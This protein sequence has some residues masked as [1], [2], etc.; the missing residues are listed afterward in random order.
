M[1]TF[2]T[3]RMS[4]TLRKL[5]KFLL[6]RNILNV[7]DFLRFPQQK[8]SR[9]HNVFYLVPLILVLMLTVRITNSCETFLENSCQF[10]HIFVFD[11]LPKHWFSFSSGITN[12]NKDLLSFFWYRNCNISHFLR[13]KHLAFSHQ[14]ASTTFS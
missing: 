12:I 3:S 1:F 2:C 8:N 5:A 10:E 13:R 14:A 7:F 4:M 6:L 11:I 9:I